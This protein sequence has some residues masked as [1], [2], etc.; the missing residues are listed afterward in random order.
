M[1]CILSFLRRQESIFALVIDCRL[2]GNGS[3]YRKS[4]NMVIKISKYDFALTK[5][6]K[7]CIILINRLSFE[8]NKNCT[9]FDAQVNKLK[10]VR[11]TIDLCINFK[12][13]TMVFF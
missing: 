6:T 9:R 11:S 7:I 8:P 2:R 3:L 1:A 10:K 5:P 4:H 13:N 12:Y